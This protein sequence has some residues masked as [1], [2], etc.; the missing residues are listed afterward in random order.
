M[1]RPLESSLLRLTALLYP[2]QASGA[3]WEAGRSSRLEGLSLA[4]LKG[5]LGVLGPRPEGAAPLPV[6]D[7]AELPQVVVSTLRPSVRR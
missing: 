7:V 3:R 1:S 6:L 4:Q 5:L 2:K